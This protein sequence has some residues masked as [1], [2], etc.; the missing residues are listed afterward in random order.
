MSN[1]WRSI[2]TK[3]GSVSEQHV[4]NSRLTCEIVTNSLR[5]WYDKKM[6]P[7][8]NL[9]YV[10]GNGMLDV[11]TTSLAYVSG[12]Q[13]HIDAINN[14]NHGAMSPWVA[15]NFDQ[16]GKILIADANDE[17]GLADKTINDLVPTKPTYI[18]NK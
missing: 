12:T 13:A 15:A 6:T 10:D 8:C 9:L 11:S 17:I 1:R 3:I 18:A 5:T 7:T 2:L 4:F 16:I 14:N